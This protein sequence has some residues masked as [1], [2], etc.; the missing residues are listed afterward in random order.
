MIRLN[1]GQIS[2]HLL[3]FFVFYYL[4]LIRTAMVAIAIRMVTVLTSAVAIMFGF[5]D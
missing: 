3:V 4:S 5:G 2:I 1:L